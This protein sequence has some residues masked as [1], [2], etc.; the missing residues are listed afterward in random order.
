MI[1]HDD[2]A[3]QQRAARIAGWFYL[4]IIAT[5]IFAEVFV[6]SRLIVSGD[7]EL[8]AGNILG[9]QVLFRVGI[10]SD[11]VMLAADVVVALA[12]YAVLRPYDRDIALLSTLLRIVMVAILGLNLLNL[13]AA[14]HYLTD[15]GLTAALE[16]AQRHALAMLALNKHA[17]GYD[18]ALVFFGMAIIALGHLLFYSRYVPRILGAG[19]SLAGIVYIG[20][21][22]ARVLA[23][24]FAVSLEPAYV[25]PLVAEL[26][27]ALWLAFRGVNVGTDRE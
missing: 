20:G 21:S 12:L 27:L 1:G 10:V 7:A 6:R 8:T 23:P 22:C 25:L 15:T 17:I 14:L 24:D 11:I 2:V 5:G 13:V 9:H 19:M 3:K 4:V 18:I 26:S 16:P